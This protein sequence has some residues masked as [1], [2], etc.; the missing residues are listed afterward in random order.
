MNEMTKE[1]I[2]KELVRKQIKENK[3]KPNMLIM[4]KDVGFY[5]KKNGIETFSGNLK[6]WLGVE[7]ENEKKN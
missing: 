5:E 1:Q 7:K 6:K 2:K 4:V 3:D